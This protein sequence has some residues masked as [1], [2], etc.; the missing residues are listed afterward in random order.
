M[1][2]E[3]LEAALGLNRTVTTLDLSRNELGDAGAERIAAALECNSTLTSV[4]LSQNGIGDHGAECIAAA[5]ERN[6]TLT[7]VFLRSNPIGQKGAE[8]IAAALERNTT[9][10]TVDTD[11]AA[12]AKRISTALERNKVGTQVLTVK[13]ESQGPARGSVI[14]TNIAGSQVFCTALEPGHTAAMLRADIVAVS[15]HR[16]NLQLVRP[17]GT[18]LDDLDELQS[19]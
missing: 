9:V 16:G 15:E 10:T 8:R 4:N 2:A 14:C 11:L 18:L 12:V 7:T 3:R 13:C 1:G 17:D 6:N 5:L 19:P